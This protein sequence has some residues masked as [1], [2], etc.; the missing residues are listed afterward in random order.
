MVYTVQNFKSLAR[1]YYTAPECLS[2]SDLYRRKKSWSLW[3]VVQVLNLGCI[4]KKKNGD[5]HAK[6]K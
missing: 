1:I 5:K 6:R 4:K 3:L 2:V